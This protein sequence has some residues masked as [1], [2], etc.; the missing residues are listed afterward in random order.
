MRGIGLQSVG[1]FTGA[2]VYWATAFHHYTPLPVRRSRGGFIELFRSHFVNI[3]ATS[4]S[5]TRTCTSCCL[6]YVWRTES[7]C[8]CVSARSRGSSSTTVRRR[9]CS[10]ET[11][12]CIASSWE[13]GSGS[14]SGGIPG[15]GAARN[16]LTRALLGLWIFH[17]LLGGGGCLNTP[18]LSRLL[19]IVEQNGKRRSKAREKS[20]R[21]HIGHFFWLRSKLRSPGVKIPKFS[22][23]V[24][25]R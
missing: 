14:C 25:G 4:G 18:R 21:N 16:W 20:F 5:V 24:F 22:K 15:G 10:G 17:H 3:G 11:V 2:D 9:G 13:S 1:A 23:M 6:G 12:S 7:A 19:R 8:R